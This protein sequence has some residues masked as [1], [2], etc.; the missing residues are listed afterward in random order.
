M[1]KILVKDIV[2]AVGGKFYGDEKILQCYISNINTDSRKKIHDSLFIPIVGKKYDAH[3]FI[4]QAFSN[5][6][7][8]VLSEKI[9]G[10]DQNFIKVNSTNQALLDLAEFYRNL[11]D[12][13]VV[14]ITGSCGKTTTKDMIANVLSQSYNVVKTQ[15]NFNNQIGLPLTIFEIEDDTQILV[16]E[17]GTNHF[18]EINSLSKVARPNV[19]VITNIGVSHIENFHSQ[20]GILKAKCEIFDYACENFLAVLNGDDEYLKKIKL[21]NVIYYGFDVLNNIFAYDIKDES[22]F[23]NILQD[24]INLNC[25]GKFMIKNA[26]AVIAIGKYFNMPDEKIK[27]GLENFKASHMRMEF[28]HSKNN[29]TI[30]NDVYNASPDSMKSSIDVLS[31]IDSKNKVCILGDMFELGDMA[32]KFHFEIGKYLSDKKIDLVICIGELA[33]NIFDGLNSNINKKYYKSKD[34]FFND[35]KNILWND[36]CVLV[37]AS[38]AM[39]FEDIIDKLM[40]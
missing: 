39:Y 13:K 32:P 18:G 40:R 27:Y 25:H 12:I 15:G 35:I 34:E 4:D 22:F 8:C 11:F 24:R 30:I 3:D 23:V 38:R 6:A 17:M 5:C 20:E 10:Q 26:L 2:K 21:P 36:S 28:L 29:L 9:L 31:N 7:V 37:K 33:K 16:L 1:K 14:A 19:C